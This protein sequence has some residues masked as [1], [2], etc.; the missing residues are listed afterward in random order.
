MSGKLLP[1]VFTAL[2]VLIGAASAISQDALNR[3]RVVL[4]ASGKLGSWVQPQSR[5]YDRVMRLAW[6]FLLRRAPV[7]SN[8]LKAYLTYCCLNPETLEA[9]D[10]PHNPAGLYGMFADSAAAYYAYSGDREVVK[11]VQSMLDY[12]LAHGM[13]PAGWDWPNVPYASS[14]AGA[15]DYRGADENH[16]C[17]LARLSKIPCGTGDGRAA[18]A[19]GRERAGPDPVARRP[20][21]HGLEPPSHG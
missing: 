17:K 12:Q 15:D 16:Y 10:W 21:R 2:A 1:R 20:H 19:H 8:G 5:A 4:D 6:A 9:K 3:H 13:T 7:E 14:D 18:A 11:L